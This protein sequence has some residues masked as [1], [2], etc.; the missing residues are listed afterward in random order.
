M[1]RRA[2]DSMFRAKR[3]H[4]S[5]ASNDK[6]NAQTVSTPRG[7]SADLRTRAMLSGAAPPAEIRRSH[8]AGARAAH[9]RIPTQLEP[10]TILIPK[11][12]D[13]TLNI[14]F[15]VNRGAIDMPSVSG[16]LVLGAVIIALLS[17]ACTRVIAELQWTKPGVSEREHRRD[18]EECGVAFDASGRPEI[19]DVSI[20][21]QVDACMRARGYEPNKAE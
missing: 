17:G 15:S 20:L 8:R 10:V 3:P 19:V 11:R 5:F 21:P 13:A 9:A 2:R 16:W 6:Q 4:S 18:L 1:G 7:Y 14:L 12:F